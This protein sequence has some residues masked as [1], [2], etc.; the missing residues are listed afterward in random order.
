MSAT[1]Q[2][3]GTTGR[4]RALLQ[5]V[6]LNIEKPLDWEKA[7][8]QHGFKVAFLYGSDYRFT[9]IR[10]FLN[11]QL[12]NQNLDPRELNGFEQNIYGGD[13]PVFAY[14][15]WLPGIGGQGTELQIGR[16]FCQFGYESVMAPSTPLMSRSYAFNWAPPF[17]H[18]GILA[19]TKVNQNL[20]VKNMF[21]NGNDVF[22]DG[23]QK[24]RYEGQILLTSDDE[25]QTLALSTTFGD[26]KFDATK[27]H[28]PV[29]GYTT[30]G[31]A[32]EPFGRNNI[33]VFD[34]VYTNKLTD[35]CTVA[36]EGIYGYQ[37]DVPAIATSSITNFNGGTGT[38]QWGGA[39]GYLQ[40][41]FNDKWSSCTRL[42]V[43][44]DCQGQRT[45]FDGTYYA[46]TFGLQFKPCKEVM[47]RPEVRYDYN[48]DSTPFNGHHGIFT[49]G[50]D[51][52]LRF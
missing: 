45:G 23:S 17:F 33:N 18:V 14:T 3:P 47:I 10:G 6:W 11:N 36:L 2:S 27:P 50:A 5:Q 4:I 20:T 35:D 42:E 31:L 32:Y 30:I 38:A 19:T 26:G 48:N 51:L 22:F 1:C 39:V 7:E 16:M 9:L 13:I 29:Q 46:G 15:A 25:K 43:F 28:G 40:Y 12:K 49:A 52:I 37:T 8:V 41:N 44:R 34:V 21:I 24:W